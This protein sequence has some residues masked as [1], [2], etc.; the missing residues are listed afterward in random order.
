MKGVM[1]QQNSCKT[2]DGVHSSY[3]ECC[4]EYTARGHS[5]C[6]GVLTGLCPHCCNRTTS[7]VSDHDHEGR[8]L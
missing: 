5:I 3:S 8:Y 7:V 1:G 4:M 2:L 6:R